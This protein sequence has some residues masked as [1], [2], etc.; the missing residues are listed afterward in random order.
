MSDESIVTQVPEITPSPTLVESTR[1][2]PKSQTEAISHDFPL[3]W[4]AKGKVGPLTAETVQSSQFWLC[5]GEDL[6]HNLS[7]MNTPPAT[8]EESNQNRV[9]PAILRSQTR[10]H[11]KGTRGS[12][13]V[14]RPV[15]SRTGS[16][17]PQ[18]QDD[19]LSETST[20]VSSSEGGDPEDDSWVKIDH[21]SSHNEGK[22]SEYEEMKKSYLA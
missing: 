7:Y 20:L 13:D 11:S 15:T 21:T 6:H 8:Q 19:G 22:S 1:Y 14:S 3:M 12:S 2:T 4:A 17:P 16:Y 10:P 5:A 18:P 9:P